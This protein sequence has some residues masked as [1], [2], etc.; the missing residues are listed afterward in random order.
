MNI[1]KLLISALMVVGLTVSA[2]E[3]I[4]HQI[5]Y[6]VTP[7]LNGTVMGSAATNVNEAFISATGGTYVN[8]A[9]TGWTLTSKGTTYTQ[10]FQMTQLATT[11]G[12]GGG[13]RVQINA[14]GATLFGDGSFIGNGSG[15]TNLPTSGAAQSPYTN[16]H[17]AATYSVTNFT[18]LT[19]VSN[20][21]VMTA[22]M[23]GGTNGVF[24]TCN[25]TNYWQLFR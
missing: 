24:W 25:G 12:K 7:Q 4:T 15:L 9:D 11:I 22:G 21:T 17:N 10:T 19:F 6:T 13:S 8:G 20:T 1:R 14:S 2:Q 16:N 3:T 5:N 18:S 23:L